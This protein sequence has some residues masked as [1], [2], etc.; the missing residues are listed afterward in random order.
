MKNRAAGLL[1]ILCVLCTLNLFASNGQNFTKA[2]ILYSESKFEEALK[3]YLDL[4]ISKL[5]S[6]SLFYNIANT[7]FRLSK[8]GSAIQYYK[9][10]LRLNPLDGDIKSNLDFA[11][12]A[13]VD[14]IE[15]STGTKVK[16]ILFF[17]YFLFKVF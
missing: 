8:I 14:K 3:L 17:W 5:E 1:M 4:E 11:R 2:N 7:Y 15:I 6:S 9:K 10:A 13:I 12:E 16:S